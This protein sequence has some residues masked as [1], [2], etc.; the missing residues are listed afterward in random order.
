MR[1]IFSVRNVGRKTLVVLASAAFAW[2]AAAQ[3]A[4]PPPLAEEQEV[5]EFRVTHRPLDPLATLVRARLSDTG[6]ILLQPARR[7][8]RVRD[9]SERIKAIRLLVSQYDVPLRRLEVVVKLIEASGAPQ[10][11]SVSEEIREIGSRLRNVLRFTSYELVDTLVLEGLEG[12]ALSGHLGGSYRVSFSLGYV[13]EGGKV[14]P[15]EVFRF[16][17]VIPAQEEGQPPF[18]QNLVSTALNLFDGE[19][20]LFGASRMDDRNERALVLVIS[21]QTLS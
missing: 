2:P 15:L 8:L 3:A 10:P 13:E 18:Y 1:R 11:E 9:A 14:I 6:E 12:R 7:V 21:V 17:K 20:I 19:E 5:V 16:D 4:D